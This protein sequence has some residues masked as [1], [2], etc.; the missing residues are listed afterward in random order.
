MS[1]S[2][3][4]F[5]DTRGYDPAGECPVKLVISKHQRNAMLPT[6]IRIPRT[7]WDSRQQKVVGISRAKAYNGLLARLKTQAEDFLLPLLYRGDLASL[8]AVE[9]RDLLAEHLHGRED[10]T[11]LSEIWKEYTATISRENT[12]GVYRDAWKRIRGWESSLDTLP[13][14]KVTDKWAHDLAEFLADN[15]APNTQRI[16]IACLS[17]VWRASSKTEGNP[18]SEVRV[19]NISTRKRDLTT[20]QMRDLWN[21]APADPAQEEAV[22]FFKASFLL[23]GI[24]PADL[25]RLAP[26]DIFNGRVEYD[27]AKTG[28]HYSV[29]VQPELL[30]LLKAHGGKGRVW[31]AGRD[32]AGY[33]RECNRQLKKVAKALH[34]PPLSMYWARHSVAS[35]LIEQGESVEIVAQALG[36]TY[37][38]PV[39]A[40]YIHMRQHKTD[41]AFRKL[42]DALLNEKCPDPHGQE[43]LR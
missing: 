23:L 27:R 3:H 25:L 24:N 28:K 30:P 32:S 10:S 31:Y 29:K 38:S 1:L 12:R 6:G 26:A 36:H 40:T 43:H 34:L 15:Y 4:Y 7:A 21:Y 18:F 14:R 37:A 33:L 2:L 42:L 19:G 5:L 17:A 20:E 8:E 16:T 22:Q 35:L 13:V 41:E 39:T 11:T 9:I